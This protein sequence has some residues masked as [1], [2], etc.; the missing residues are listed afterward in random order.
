[1]LTFIQN[2]HAIDFNVIDHIEKKC[3]IYQAY[4]PKSSYAYGLGKGRLK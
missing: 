3:K 4:T 1:M 2:C